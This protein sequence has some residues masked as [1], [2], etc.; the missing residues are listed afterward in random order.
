MTNSERD[1]CLAAILK[2]LGL[3]KLPTVEEPPPYHQRDD[4]LSPAELSFY[5]VL[6]NTVSDGATVCAKVS[7]Q[8]LF[9][10]KTGDHSQNRSWMNRIDRKHVD[11]LLCDPDTMRP[12]IGVELDDASHQRAKQKERDQIVNRAFEVSGL[13]LVRV[14]AQAQYNTRELEALLWRAMESASTEPPAQ[15]KAV[16]EPSPDA[17]SAP[18]ACPRCGTPMVL[19]EVKKKGPRQGTKFWG[20]PNFPKCRGVREIDST[21]VEPTE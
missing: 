15:A 5:H 17:L 4:F 10:A 16:Q 19:R 11:F 3:S 9:F 7:L 8:D 13:P 12:L 2:M 14:T 18:P 21:E 6:K 20:C 1:G